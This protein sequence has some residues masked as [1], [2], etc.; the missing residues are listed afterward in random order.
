MGTETKFSDAL[1][2]DNGLWSAIRVRTILLSFSVLCLSFNT[3]ISQT[4]A[5]YPGYEKEGDV[6]VRLPDNVM[7]VQAC[8]FW[9]EE[10]F[11]PGGY[12]TFIDQAS[13]HSPY[14]LLSASIR[15]PG[16]ETTSDAVH[17]QIKLAAE[18]AADHGI[19]LIA[20]LDVRTARRAFESEYPDELQEM[21][22]LRDVAV[23]KD[24][25]AEA[26]IFSKDLSDHYTGNTTHYIPLY[27]RLL[28]VYSFA[29]EQDE[30]DPGSIKDITRNC[31]VVSASKD[32]V[33][34]SIPPDGENNRACVLV[35]FTHLYPDVF[36]PHLMEFQRKIIRQYADAPLAGVFK[37]E[38]GF[39]PCFDGSPLKDEFWYSKYRAQAYAER[40]GG[41]DLLADCLLMHLKVKGREQERQMVINHF[42]EMSWQRNGALEDD[43]YH[44]VKEVFGPNAVV[45]PHPTWWPYPDLREYMKNGLDWWVA[46]RDWAQTDE[47]TPFAVRTALAKK[48]G[49]P[50]WYNMFYSTSRSAYEYSIW[51]YALAGGRI[52]YHPLYPSDLKGIEKHLGL[53]KGELMQAESRVRL[54]N[55][56]SRSPLNCPVAVV[57]G[58]ACTMNWA[59][60]LYD[61]VGMD[62]VNRFWLEGIPA[63]LIPASEIENGNLIVDRDGFVRYGAQ[64]YA[65]VILY[66]PEFERSSTADFFNKV[67]QDKTSL[68]RVG[69][70]TLDF[71]AKKFDGN[72]ALPRTV[73]VSSNIEQM[74][75]EVKKILHN[76]N[77]ELQTPAIETS[78]HEFGHT[79]VSPPAAGY[80]HLLDGTYIRVAGA[81]NTSGDPI[82]SKIKIRDQAVYFDALGLAAVRL[83]EKGRVE[84]LAAG[85]LR[86]F[87][88]GSLKIGL[89]KRMDLALWKNG[90]GEWTGV[91]QGYEGKIPSQLLAITRNWIR[92]NLPAPFTE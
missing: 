15:L 64:R 75:S 1:N 60:P 12:K 25:N 53:L 71:N 18:Y 14:N 19:S 76:K 45:V 80:C 50:V 43:F 49:S 11:K 82:R 91:I 79:V 10:E 58:H 30:A 47:V 59:T 22:L 77:I 24:K 41:R 56:I 35:S 84:A 87:R 54:L 23:N 28:R 78:L 34:V 7:P 26:V 81:H 20:D 46:T 67:A 9:S 8:W 61:D 3:G 66:H 74:L 65:A 29:M 31:V 21:L 52:N 32:S 86:S 55:F 88:S 63:D 33:K 27:G 5:E 40:T 57:F 73:F 42:M 70:W 68:F 16:R 39:P 2:D 37:D 48:W 51:S 83:D 85:G 13:I 38:W 92:I 6:S 72:K 62:L 36:A 89:D 4:Q 44:A 17:N 90:Q 69:D